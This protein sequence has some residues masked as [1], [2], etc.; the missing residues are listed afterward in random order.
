MTAISKSFTTITDAQVDADS[1]ITQALMTALRD[2][3]IHLREWLGA[4]YTGGAVQDHNHDGVNSALI[5]V[6]PNYL[7]NGS[8]ESGE[9]AWT[10]QDFTGGTHAIE[11]S[12]GS[13]GTKR[14]AFT[15]TSTANGGGQAVSNDYIAC[16]GGEPFSMQF[17]AHASV[18]N[19]SSNVQFIWYD[20]AK[21]QISTTD[22]YSVA[23][24]NLAATRNVVRAE[25]P[26]NARYVRVKLVGGVPGSGSS[27]GT[28]YFD[29]VRVMPSIEQ[30]MLDPAAVGQAELKTTT[31]S[32][33]GIGSAH[34]TLPGGEY[35][36][37]PRL[38]NT[39]NGGVTS[40]FGSSWTSSTTDVTVIYLS[41]GAGTTTATQRYVQA[42]PPYDLG[43]GAIPLFGFVE[44]ESGTPVG[45][46]FAPDP[47]WANNGPTNIRGDV[48]RNGRKY[49]WERSGALR[50]MRAFKS[51]R[52]TPDDLLA[53]LKEPPEL[54]EITQAVK[55]ADM[56]LI[57]HPFLGRAAGR[58]FVMLDPVGRQSEQLADLHA[59]AIDLG[60]LILGGYIEVSG[61]PLDAQAPPG[62]IPVGWKWRNTGG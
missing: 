17:W 5:E 33:S 32:V 40:S 26:S 44:L 62:V 41:A 25:A 22:V 6:G 31:G 55:Q 36:F 19:V 9:S 46:W 11:A 51:G 23:D 37:Y 38:R 8:F 52:A 10:I 34:Y 30:Y 48:L 4:S 45:A 7:R 3:H 14:L 27:T 43:N 15:S 54:V 18:S 60:E 53:A 49:R 28:V 59:Q 21:S 35:G 58:S 1:P 2:N 50:A 42:S 24:T 13:Q 57:P 47:P 29:G 56:P 39:V 12:G 20:G 61:D 16:G